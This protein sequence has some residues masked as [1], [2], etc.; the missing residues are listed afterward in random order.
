MVA[1]QVLH[2]LLCFWKCRIKTIDAQDTQRCVVQKYIFLGGNVSRCL[3]IVV[4]V[5]EDFIGDLLPWLH[6]Q[7]YRPNTQQQIFNCL[8]IGT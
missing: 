4:T 6:S 7:E 8:S 3:V 5:P 1:F 2:P